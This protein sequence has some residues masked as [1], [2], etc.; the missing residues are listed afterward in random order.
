MRIG[1]SGLRVRSSRTTKAATS[2][3]PAAMKSSAHGSVQ[4]LSP[5]PPGCAFSCDAS[6]TRVK[7]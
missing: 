4:P 2:T 6:A 1:S 7:P 3:I 5:L